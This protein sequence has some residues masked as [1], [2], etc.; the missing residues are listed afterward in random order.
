MYFERQDAFY[1]QQIRWITKCRDLG[2]A[3]HDYVYK[4]EVH[5]WY[6]NSPHVEYTTANVDKFLVE[7]GLLDEEPNV[8]LPHKQ[9]SASRLKIQKQKYPR[10]TDWDEQPRFRRYVER[11]DIE[12]IPFKH[13]DQ[14]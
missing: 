8:E 10:K 6:N 4:G 13:Y 14:R 9:I 12:P 5:S 7:I 11:H 3:C 1:P 2:L